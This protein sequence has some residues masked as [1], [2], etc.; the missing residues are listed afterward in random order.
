MWM[1]LFSPV[2]VQNMKPWIG[3]NIIYSMSLF[4]QYYV[5]LENSNAVHVCSLQLYSNRGR[6][7]FKLGPRNGC[8]VSIW[9]IQPVP[10]NSLLICAL[11]CRVSNE[12]SPTSM[13]CNQWTAAQEKK[14][15]H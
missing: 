2:A 15:L 6:S 3:K 12:S 5:H 8:Q 1:P 9:P 13:F 10:D 4:S 11:C 14:G 7:T